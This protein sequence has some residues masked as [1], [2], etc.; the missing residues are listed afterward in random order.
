MMRNDDAVSP[1]IGVILMVAITV[2]LAAVIAMF[3]FNMADNVQGGKTVGV[4]AKLDGNNIAVTY[5][6]G[7]DDASLM[8]LKIFAN[9]ETYFS[10]AATA[11]SHVYKG[12][13]SADADRPE[14]GWKMIVPKGSTGSVV[15][16]GKFSD[17]TEVPLLDKIL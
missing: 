8:Y 16:T 17:G 12:T 1:V 9:G 3:V 5:M 2:I 7:P 10:D 14:V 4:T 15:V 13:D 11:T 6:G